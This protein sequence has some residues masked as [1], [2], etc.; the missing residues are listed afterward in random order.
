MAQYLIV[1][2]CSVILLGNL[3]DFVYPLLYYD[4]VYIVGFEGFWF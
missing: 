1:D 3:E 2:N 4:T